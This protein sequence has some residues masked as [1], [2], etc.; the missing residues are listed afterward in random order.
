M[1]RIVAVLLALISI[2]S[3]GAT[4]RGLPVG[5]CSGSILDSNVIPVWQSGTDTEAVELGMKFQTDG[6]SPITGVRFYKAGLNGGTHVGKLW[7]TSGQLLQSV[8]FT[9]ETATGW[10][11]ATFSTPFQPQAN[12]TY[13]VSYYAPQGHYA[14]D[15][16]VFNNSLGSLTGVGLAPASSAVGGNGVYKYGVGGG[17]PDQTYQSPNYY[18][19]II[20]SDKKPPAAPTSLALGSVTSTTAVISWVAT[21]GKQVANYLINRNGTLV[22]TLPG[23]ALTFS[24]NNLNPQTIYTYTVQAKDN[25]GNISVVSNSL[26]VTTASDNPP[27]PPPPDTGITYTYDLVKDFGAVAGNTAATDKAFKAFNV[28]A[29]KRTRPPEPGYAGYPGYYPDASKNNTIILKIPAGKFTYSWNQFGINIPRLKIIGAGSGLKGGAS[30]SLQNVNGGQWF[31][32]MPF[33]SP[34]DYFGDQYYLVWNGSYWVGQDNYGY[35]IKTAQAGDTKVTFK[36]NPAYANKF[37]VGR[38]VLVYSYSQQQY[39]YPPNARYYDWAKV[40][41][42]DPVAGTVT[43]DTPLQFTHRSDRPYFGSTLYEQRQ[44][45]SNPHGQVGPALIAAIDTPDKPLGEFHEYDGMHVLPN[46]NWS[47]SLPPSASAEVWEV[48]GL[49]DGSM[50][51]MWLDRAV[52]HTQVR[53]FTVSNSKWS[54]DE[55]DKIIGNIT[56]INCEV[57]TTMKH[58]GQLMWH[59][60]GGHIGGTRL[61]ARNAWFE[62]T[63]FDSMPG[64]NLDEMNQTVSILVDGSTFVGRGNGA[65][66]ITPP[67]IRPYNFKIDGTTISLPNGPNSSRLKVVK[68]TKEYGDAWQMI[69]DFLGDGDQVYKNGAPV[70]GATI[71]LITGDANYIYV[72]V[73]GVTFNNGDSFSGARVQNLTVK[74]SFGQNTGFSWATPWS[75]LKTGI[76]NLV[77]QN[78]S[79]N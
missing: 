17:F 62:N 68:T 45:S 43:L 14:R 61:A 73:A 49:I 11:T 58:S 6:S 3:F 70:K 25:C 54:Y 77:W 13:I 8:T 22:A 30:T 74:N 42:I 18:V 27:P 31:D 72:D 1:Q 26:D 64:I 57:A 51:D 76:A 5:A 65:Q 21:V 16:N 41:A 15:A 79:G 67:D 46:P 12:T 24:D 78:N 63:R 48:G 60:I 29:Q 4:T 47:P 55:S 75:F 38:W 28:E 50:D 7:T 23:A 69:V 39:G 9:N 44:K 10:Q 40:T 71:A 34:W 36:N 33:R 56:Y 59:V 53:N 66:P 35:L 52:Q 37:F 2:N 19:D 20:V 32:A